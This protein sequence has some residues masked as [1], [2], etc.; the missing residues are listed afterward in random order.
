MLRLTDWD[1]RLENLKTDLGPLSK[2]LKLDTSVHQRLGEISSSCSQGV[3][4]DGDGSRRL[5]GFEES[6]SLRYK[7]CLGFRL[8]KLTSSVLNSFMSL[9]TRNVL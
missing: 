3:G 5:V 9:P 4:S 7:P 2:R 6:K 1:R 8:A